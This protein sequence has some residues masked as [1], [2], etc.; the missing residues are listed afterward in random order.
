MGITQSIPAL[1][2]REHKFFVEHYDQQV[3]QVVVA[4]T[5]GLA[6]C[7]PYRAQHYPH[8]AEQRVHT[9]QSPLRSP[10]FSGT[11]PARVIGS[12]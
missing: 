10:L 2:Q 6:T 12:T 3:S 11:S 5:F 9:G 8:V 1:T 4:V 7:V